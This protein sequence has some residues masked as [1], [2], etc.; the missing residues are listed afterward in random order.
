MN[1]YLLV[2]LE[3]PAPIEEEFNDWYDFEHIPERAGLPGFI[4]AKRFTCVDGWPRY[5][6]IYDLR[7]IGVLEEAPYRALSGDGFSPWSKR[8]LNRVR[9]Q[10]RASGDQIYPGTALTGDFC[11]MLLIRFGNVP[12]SSESKIVER[13]RSK[14]E[15]QPGIKQVRVV[16]NSE[17][18]GAEYLVLVESVLPLPPTSLDVEAFGDMSPFINMINE[19]SPYWVRGH[20]PGVFAG[21]K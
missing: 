9:G 3:P 20:L 5:L 2:T 14:F 1:G 19:Y 15:G 10:Y 18:K 6:A 12:D 7:S 4:T 16:R 17:A 21:T 8:V 11:R 13:A